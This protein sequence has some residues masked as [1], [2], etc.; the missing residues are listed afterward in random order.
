MLEDGIKALAQGANYAIVTSVMPDG[1]VQ[2]QPLWIDGD[3]EHLMFNTERDR[4]RE[5][6]YRRDKRCTITIV[7]AD[8]WYHWAEVRGEV[9]E[10]IDGPEARAHID[11]LAMKYT[12]AAYAN[13]IT[14]ERLIIKVRPNRQKFIKW[15]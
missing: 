12:G 10:V 8:G 9:V 11:K 13:P 7:G 2:A 14:T 1:D 6:N 5:R 3:D 15:A 4:Q